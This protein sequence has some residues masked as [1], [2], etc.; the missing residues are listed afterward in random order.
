MVSAI[1]DSLST[2]IEYSR[3]T[4]STLVDDD[5]DDDR[6]HKSHWV[7]EPSDQFSLKPPRRS[8]ILTRLSFMSDEGCN[9]ST[10]AWT[11]RSCDYR[12]IDVLNR[13]C[14][15]CGTGRTI[16]LH[17]REQN[18][19]AKP[20][21][22]ARSP[23][24]HEAS[25]HP[26]VSR[27]LS[28]DHHS[29]QH[30][31]PSRSIDCGER[32]EYESPRPV[33]STRPSPTALSSF[34]GKNAMA[35]KKK[36]GPPSVQS[37][38]STIP[39]S[40]LGNHQMFAAIPEEREN[41]RR[42]QHDCMV[43]PS[44]PRLLYD[45]SDTSCAKSRVPHA[46]AGAIQLKNLFSD[47]QEVVP[48]V[49]APQPS[50]DTGDDLDRDVRLRFQENIMKL[51]K[52][53]RTSTENQSKDG[54]TQSKGDCGLQRVQDTE[55]PNHRTRLAQFFDDEICTMSYVHSTGINETS[56]PASMWSMGSRVSKL[57][58][59]GSAKANS[60]WQFD[61]DC[62]LCSVSSKDLNETEERFNRSTPLDGGMHNLPRKR[63]GVSSHRTRC[64][65]MYAVL[66]GLLILVGIIVLSVTLSRGHESDLAQSILEDQSLTPTSFAPTSSAPTSSTPTSSPTPIVVVAPT[67]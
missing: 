61:S 24:R 53:V 2:T 17:K 39:M 8:K 1:I 57:W 9:S 26:P 58:S 44:P 56:L 36:T 46:T 30:L 28:S 65:V 23:P 32:N 3:P 5:D 48:R 55:P 31:A 50:M 63:N 67:D 66:G 27:F 15:L 10:T 34:F 4:Q 7:D 33:P 42:P 35:K 14:A 21:W 54:D 11:C 29:N 45:Q 49:R 40:N 37:S 20:D 12:N 64:I 62:A 43:L 13:T 18:G 19:T 59:L 60:P 41:S 16:S 6:A 52:L 25:Q 22:Q 47:D 51:K 38:D